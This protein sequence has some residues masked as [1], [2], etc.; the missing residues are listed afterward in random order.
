MGPRRG[1]LGL[2][3]KEPS[4]DTL[5]HEKS[6]HSYFKR[7]AGRSTNRYQSCTF[8]FY[9]D[10][11]E[12]ST[13]AKPRS[14]VSGIEGDQD[15]GCG[16]SSSEAL[17]ASTRSIQTANHWLAVAQSP[18]LFPCKALLADLSRSRDAESRL[19]QISPNGDEMVI[20][21]APL[22]D[23]KGSLILVEPWGKVIV[24]VYY[25]QAIL[26]A[27]L[28][29]GAASTVYTLS[30]SIG[31]ITNPLIELVDY[32]RR[33]VPGS[34]FRPIPQQGPV[35]LRTL[36]K[37]FN[38]MVVQLTR[39]QTSLRQYTHKALLSQEEE[40]QRLSQEL[41]DETMQNLV[42]LVQRVELCR[43]EME[44]DSLLAR[45][46]LDELQ[47]LLE[48]TLGDVRRISNALAAFDLGG[49]WPANSPAGTLQRSRTADA[50]YPLPLHGNRSGATTRV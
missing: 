19:I 2:T 6:Y 1:N 24:P 49:P 34:I 15:I 10:A 20:S 21:Y 35:E 31:R 22:P 11:H 30:L 12:R 7:I 41:H 42:G 33:A 29:L 16:H 32:A 40:R 38:L 5:Y 8:T 27:L 23:G 43:S 36:I 9:V 39:Q 46:R 50:I 26:I 14:D 37:F 3:N 17:V 45:R 48:I 25:L 44:R 13:F 18:P 28:I 4:R 47:E